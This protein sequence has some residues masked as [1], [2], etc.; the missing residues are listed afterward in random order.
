[1]PSAPLWSHILSR[2]AGVLGYTH[3][4][5]VNS[6]YRWGNVIMGISYWRKPFHPVLLGAFSEEK[7]CLHCSLLWAI[8]LSPLSSFLLPSW[9]PMS[10]QF[11]IFCHHLLLFQLYLSLSLTH[12]L[13]CTDTSLLCF[14]GISASLNHTDS[15]SPP[16]PSSVSPFSEEH[17]ANPPGLCSYWPLQKNNPSISHALKREYKEKLETVASLHKADPW[18]KGVMWNNDVL[19]VSVKWVLGVNPLIIN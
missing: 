5:E 16:S 11:L 8:S 18:W 13:T 2:A 17:L 14:L 3:A 19:F 1:M 6:S 12:S 9:S 7:K 10:S 15:H 4:E